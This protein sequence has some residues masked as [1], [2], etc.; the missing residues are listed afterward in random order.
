MVL[1]LFSFL[2]K[3]ESSSQTLGRIVEKKKYTDDE[4]QKMTWEQKSDLIQK[5][6]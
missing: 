4:I 1:L 5:I 3:V 2:N 6:L